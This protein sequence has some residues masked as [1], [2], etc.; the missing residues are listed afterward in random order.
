[1][2]KLDLTMEI[3]KRNLADTNSNYMTTEFH[4]RLTL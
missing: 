2:F 1:M 3:W 4:V